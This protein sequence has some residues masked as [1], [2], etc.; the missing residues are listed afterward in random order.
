MKLRG[1]VVVAATAGL[2]LLFGGCE[3]GQRALLPLAE[4]AEPLGTFR[5][6][7]Q[8]DAVVHLTID[9]GPSASTEELLEILEGFGA[10][11]TFFI[12]TGHVEDTAILGR[13]VSAGHNLGN[14]MPA[15]RDWSRDDEPSF[16]RA[17][18]ESHC[19]LAAYGDGYTGAFRPPQGRIAADRMLPVLTDA[20]VAGRR[21]FLM[22]SFL[23]WDAGG[24]TETP[25][26]RVNDAVAARY[27]AGLGRAVRPGDIVVF[28][29]GPRLRRTA[30]TR[31]SLRRFLDRLER[32]GLEARALPGGAFDSG[33][34]N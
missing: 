32:R 15:D 13:I 26:R 23:P 19:L 17:F 34:C 20:G 12:H 33:P 22:A 28:H 5:L 3:T 9:D 10:T 30:A 21:P 27:G 24:A 11:A 18:L 25:W 16:R 7:P 31:E 4:R 29:D 8:E 6:A 2:F 1:A 14:H